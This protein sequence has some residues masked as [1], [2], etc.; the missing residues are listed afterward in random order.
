MLILLQ[1]IVIAIMILYAAVVNHQRY[2]QLH[3]HVIMAVHPS[4]LSSIPNDRIQ[5]L[6]AGD[7]ISDDNLSAVATGMSMVRIH[8]YTLLND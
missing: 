7:D 1:W 8:C 3:Q 2:H 4:P 6:S 5:L